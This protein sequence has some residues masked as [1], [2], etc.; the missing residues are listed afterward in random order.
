MKKSHFLDFPKQHLAED[1]WEGDP[2]VLKKRVSSLI[3]QA[4]SSLL[5]SIKKQRDSI[6]SV[7]IT[8][9]LTG[10]SYDVNSDLDVHIIFKD[11]SGI[12]HEK[13]KQIT[14]ILSEEFKID[15]HPVQFYAEGYSE[16]SSKGWFENLDKVYDLD[17]KEWL[18]T[19]DITIADPLE[20]F[21]GIMERARSWAQRLDIDLGDAR[22][23]LLTFQTLKEQIEGVSPAE[24]VIIIKHIQD[25]KNDL[26]GDIQVLL[27]D[28]EDIH[29]SRA[30][31]FKKNPADLDTGGELAE[32]Y[33]S[34]N[35]LPANLTFKM[36]ERWRYLQLL[37]GIQKK[38]QQ[39]VFEDYGNVPE[40]TFT[41]K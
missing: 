28:L 5:V 29:D 14:E 41:I 15:T 4:I 22:R 36:L 10:K 11:N 7:I 38:Y 35:L 12:D 19:N 24:R 27:G 37:K 16:L 18:K 13:T 39:G 40:D 2:P 17:K 31:S 6:Y 25:L 20:K 23:D 33:H 26:D 8:G 21:K 1:I 9:S 30:Q 32:E 34:K 3:Q